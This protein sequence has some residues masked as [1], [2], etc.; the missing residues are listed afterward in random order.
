[1]MSF[2]KKTSIS[3]K[4]NRLSDDKIICD[5]SRHLWAKKGC[6]YHNNVS[7]NHLGNIHIFRY[8]F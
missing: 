4:H 1:M 3:I 5:Q 7:F 8:N 6:F 2:A